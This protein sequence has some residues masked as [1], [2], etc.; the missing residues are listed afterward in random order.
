[1]RTVKVCLH[2][3]QDMLTFLDLLKPFCGEN[4]YAEA[5]ATIP[6]SKRVTEKD[7]VVLGGKLRTFTHPLKGQVV[8]VGYLGKGFYSV[9]VGCEDNPEETVPWQ[10]LAEVAPWVRAA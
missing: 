9:A 2:D 5:L 7:D 4:F 6:K 8:T 10:R 3:K 1:M